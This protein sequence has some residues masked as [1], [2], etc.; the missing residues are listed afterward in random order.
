MHKALQGGKR[1]KI[2]KEPISPKIP[3]I[4]TFSEK[5]NRGN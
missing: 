4:I 3:Q 2:L 5:K 1:Y